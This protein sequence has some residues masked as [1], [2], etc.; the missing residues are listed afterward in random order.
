M[1][2]RTTGISFPRQNNEIRAHI[3]MS[4]NTYNPRYSHQVRPTSFLC[5][6]IFGGHLA[7]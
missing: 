7:H 5:V 4:S 3:C 2:G 6:L 1:L